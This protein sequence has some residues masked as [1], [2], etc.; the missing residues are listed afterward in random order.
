MKTLALDVAAALLAP[1]AAAQDEPDTVPDEGQVNWPVAAVGLICMA[2]GALYATP[3]PT[4]LG[5]QFRC[6]ARDPYPINEGLMVVGAGFALFVLRTTF[7][8]SPITR[9]IDKCPDRRTL[10]HPRRSLLERRRGRRPI[11]W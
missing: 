6:L 1:P 5:C 8:E 2:T 10:V 4:P 3:P 11:S 7:P 9:D